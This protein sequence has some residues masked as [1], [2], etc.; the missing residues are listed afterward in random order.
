MRGNTGFAKR[1]STLRLR[2][3][4]SKSDLARKVDVSTTCVWNW[5]EGNTHPRPEALTKISQVLETTTA[6]LEYGEASLAD[7]ELAALQIGRNGQHVSDVIQA[8]RVMVAEATGLAVD[9]VK[10]ILEYGRA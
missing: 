7:S 4:L 10:V 6:F 1:L 3:G 5:E 2:Q 8:A 9:K